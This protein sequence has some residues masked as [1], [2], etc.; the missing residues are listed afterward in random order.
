[1]TTAT[2]LDNRLPLPPF[3]PSGRGEDTA[4]GV[5]VSRCLQ[6]TC[7]GYVPYG[8]LHAPSGKRSF[9]PLDAPFRTADVLMMMLGDLKA[10]DDASFA[11]RF[12][13]VGSSFIELGHA[14]YHDFH[15]YV[16]GKANQ[17]VLALKERCES[18]LEAFRWEPAPW[19]Q[20]MRQ[21]IAR[22]DSH[23]MCTDLSIPSDI[24]ERDSSK[25]CRLLQQFIGKYGEALRCWPD[26]VACAA[27]MRRNGVRLGTCLTD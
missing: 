8:L 4:F 18:A 13:S 9:E 7:T 2:G 27:R 14:D 11:Q 21:W 15:T 16:L 17:Y 6:G 20:E 19:A 1:M 22:L 3:I 24:S 10:I 23:L 5:T 25:K 26:V 12:K